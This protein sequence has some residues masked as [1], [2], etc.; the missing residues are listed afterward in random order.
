[1]QNLPEIL[2]MHEVNKIF[3]ILPTS[4]S[5]TLSLTTNITNETEEY[6]CFP[7]DTPVHITRLYES[8]LTINGITNHTLSQ[9]KMNNLPNHKVPVKTTT[10][11]NKINML[12]TQNNE[13]SK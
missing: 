2:V 8:F 11:K 9:M 5:L 10:A 4:F 7:T 13:Q 1:M 6:L 3:N 12:T